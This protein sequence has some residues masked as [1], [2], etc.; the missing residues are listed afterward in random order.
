LLS[1]GD[2]LAAGGYNSTSGYLASAELYASGGG[3]D[4]T[5]V[6]AASVKGL[7]AIDLPL[8]GPSGVEDRSGG[9]NKKYRVVM[10][11]DQ[12]ITSVG[13][14]SSTCGAVQ[15]IVIDSSDAHEVNFNLV[16]VAHG[17]NEST[18]TITANSISDDQGNVLDSASVPLGL[19]LGDVNGDRV[20]DRHDTN[21]AQ[22]H[23]GQRA[24]RQNFRSD[25]NADGHITQADIA[26]IRQQQGTS[27][28]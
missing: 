13:S 19:L 15:S 18:I 16:N 14:A 21:E 27:L 22:M 25:V 5:L 3:A 4:L 28:P 12:N 1:N 9:P 8:T 7:F 24:V 10:T 2:V 11:F 20:V 17:C 23:K 6:S 26:L